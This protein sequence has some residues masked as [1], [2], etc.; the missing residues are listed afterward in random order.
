MNNPGKAKLCRDCFAT[1]KKVSYLSATDP[2][3]VFD[4]GVGGLSILKEVRL[5][6]PKEDLLYFADSKYCPYG[7]KTPTFIKERSYKLT[8]FL[9]TKGAKLIIVACN[10]ASVTAL[11][12]LRT[13]YPDV[14]F[15]GVEPAIKQGVLYSRN[16]KV[17]VLATGVTLSGERFYSLLKRYAG[18]TLIFTQPCHGLVERI[19]AGEVEAGGETERIVGECTAPLIESGVDVIILGCTHY[20]F[21]RSL[22]EKKVGPGVKIIDTGAPVAR[23]A[24]R[25]LREHNLL[26]QRTKGGREFFFTSGHPQAVAPVIH[27]LWGG[28]GEGVSGQLL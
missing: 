7:A 8:E 17:G 14:H 19:E 6:L 5:L 23:Q 20:P 13:K 3:G 21:I 1:N 10:T 4:S 18:E 12:D 11:E 15:V 22:V 2:I 9:L 16:H 28:V 25:V 27:R 24:L 26:T